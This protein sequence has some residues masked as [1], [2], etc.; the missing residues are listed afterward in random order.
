MWRRST[1]TGAWHDKVEGTGEVV[2][3]GSYPTKAEAQAVGRDYARA[4]K[5]EHIIRNLNGQIGGRN[6]Y[7]HDLRNIPG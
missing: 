4:Q 7:G 1:K 6:T 2:V 3:G 5:V